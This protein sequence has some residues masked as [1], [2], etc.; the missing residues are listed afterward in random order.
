DGGEYDIR[1]AADNHVRVTL[2]GNTGNTAVDV[3]ITGKQ[4]TVGVKN[5]PHSN[6]KAVIEVPKVADL[7]VHLTGGDLNVGAVTGNKDIS[8]TAGDVRIE[9]GSGADYASVDAAV[10]IGDMKT[11]PFGGGSSGLLGHELKWTGKGKYTLRARLGAGDLN[12]K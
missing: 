4:A 9:V 8:A 3:A 5:T 12:L 1:A 6:F 7:V 2:S 10:R 11:G